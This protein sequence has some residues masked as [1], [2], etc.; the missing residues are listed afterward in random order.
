MGVN[1]S[2]NQKDL[3][4]DTEW[5]RAVV[6][7]HLK[8]Q[9]KA[10][11][12]K[13]E[14][15]CIEPVKSKS[16]EDRNGEESNRRKPSSGGSTSSNSPENQA[17]LTPPKTGKTK[18]RRKSKFRRLSLNFALHQRRPSN[19]IADVASTTIKQEEN[20]YS[21]FDSPF[22][23]RSPHPLNFTPTPRKGSAK[24]DFYQVSVSFVNVKG[25]ELRKL[26]ES[27]K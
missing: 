12:S 14:S 10:P 26:G 3:L 7:Y 20:S 23:M 1:F 11:V 9:R 21:L 6:E 22:L 16:A 17:A 15:F 4:E 2:R 27:I 18:V 13:F 24:P 5:L 19:V 25:D 8:R